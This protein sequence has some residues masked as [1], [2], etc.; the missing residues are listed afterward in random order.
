M[1]VSTDF[2]YYRIVWFISLL[3]LTSNF[4]H[5][6]HINF[7]HLQIDFVKVILTLI[8]YRYIS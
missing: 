1:K 3:I 4:H 2:P 8:Q 7:L 6:N 5:S